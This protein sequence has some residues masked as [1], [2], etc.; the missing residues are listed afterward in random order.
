MR[1]IDKI[2]YIYEKNS[3]SVT[4]NTGTF[5]ELKNLLN[6]HETYEIIF[7][8]TTEKYFFSSINDLITLINKNNFYLS[9][10]KAD[11][12][13]KYRTIKIISNF[14]NRYENKAFILKK[15]IAFLYSIV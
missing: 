2:A 6:R 13:I 7:D 15:I 3:D 12:E 11:E 1:C 10:V 9:L 4:R 14:I 5:L 8:Q